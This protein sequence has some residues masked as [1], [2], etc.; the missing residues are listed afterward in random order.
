MDL[1]INKILGGYDGSVQEVMVK[2]LYIY[3][4]I[5]IEKEVVNVRRYLID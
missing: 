2:S 5:L 4:S 3:I 1:S